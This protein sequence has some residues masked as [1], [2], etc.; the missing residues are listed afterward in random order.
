MLSEPSAEIIEK[1]GVTGAQPRVLLYSPSLRAFHSTLIGNL[2]EIAKVYPVVL[3]LPEP[4]DKETKS[5][6]EKHN[7][8]KLQEV[9][10]LN[11]YGT[12]PGNL[13]DDISCFCRTAR[14]VIDTY[15]PDIVIASSDLHTM[16]ELFLMR[17]SRESGALNIALQPNLQAV[18]TKFSALW[19]DLVHACS[20]PLLPMWL[21]LSVRLFAVKCR[22]AAGHILCYWILPLS[23][24]QRPFTG[25]SSHILRTGNAGMR[26]A[27]YSIVFS[28]KERQSF[29]RD[30]VPPEKLHILP[31]PLQRETRKFLKTKFL[32]DKTS[33]GQQRRIITLLLPGE[34]LGFKKE[35][36]DLIPARQRQINRLEIV[37]LIADILSDWDIIIKPHPIIK[38]EELSIFG[39][40]SRRVE[41]VDPGESAERLIEISDAVIGFP[42]SASTALYTAAMQCP[43]KALISLDTDDEYLGD[44]F[45]NINGIEYVC[46]KH[47]FVRILEDIKNNQYRKKTIAIQ[48]E[49]AFSDTAAMIGHLW[50]RKVHEIN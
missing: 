49:G 30:G 9:V 42:R 38:K 43:E 19:V 10:I 22:K 13:R 46:G 5:L 2:Y 26:S 50:E 4:L 48:E 15:K 45:K 27:D 39:N 33:E 34:L 16:F 14:H 24:R 3:V 29:L 35:S 20:L 6:L 40:I 25:K 7:F 18:E 11:Q 47:Q 41:I 21:P 32:K 36:Y 31:H 1:R 23:L 12:S 44:I 17:F 37:K 8:P 28:E